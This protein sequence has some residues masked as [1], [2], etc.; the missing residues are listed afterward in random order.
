MANLKDLLGRLGKG[1]KGLGTGVTLLAAA[2]ATAI[3][4]NQSLYTG[5]HM[6]FFIFVQFSFQ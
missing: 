5:L 4:I 1:P 3:G 2:G 6:F